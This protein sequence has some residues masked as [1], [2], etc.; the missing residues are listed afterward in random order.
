VSDA[1]PPDLDYRR[2][3]MASPNAYAVLSPDLRIIDANPAW[4]SLVHGPP[5][6]YIGR[7]FF[8]A[9]PAR[10]D[11]AARDLRAMFHRVLDRKRPETIPLIHY[12]LP[13]L[14]D[15]GAHGPWQDRYWT[16]NCAPLLGNDGTVVAILAGPIDITDLVTSRE[17]PDD[18]PGGA[19]LRL[20]EQLAGERRRFRQLMQQAPGFIAVGHGS[21]HVFELVNDAYYQLVGHRDIIGKPVRE[22]LPE[23]EGQGFY[24]LL[25]RVYATGEPFIGRAMPIQLQL[26]PGAPPVERYIDFIYQ[27]ILGEDGAVTGIFVQGHDV[28]DAHELAVRVSHQA[29]HDALTGLVNRREFEARLSRLFDG[30][31]DSTA[32][33]ALIYLDLDQFKVVNDT[34]GH[35]AGDELLRQVADVLRRHV[36][37]CHT[38]ARLGGDEFGLLLEDTGTESARALAETLRQAIDD[39]EYTRDQR[40]FGCSASLGVVAFGSEIGGITDALSAADSACFLAKEK[41]RNRVQMHW[42]DDDELAERRREM[43]W[44]GRLREALSDGRILLYAQRIAALRAAPERQHVELLVRLR[45][46]DGS[47][48]PPMAFIP[49]AERY[50]VM[51]AVDRHVIAAA[52]RHLASMAPDERSRIS[53]SVNLSGRTL[54][55]EN[56]VP[57]IRGLLDAMPVH[58]GEICFEVTETA[59]V[60][61]LAHTTRLLHELRAM[62]FCFALDDFGSG[63]SS[64]SYLKHLPVDFLKID[65]AFIRNVRHDRADAAMVEAIARVAKVMDIR[66]VAEYVED[67]ETCTLLTGLGVDYAQGFGVH[68]P[69]PLETLC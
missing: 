29:A 20:N 16:V 52:F 65:G 36:H 41:G 14:P 7:Y 25:D 9:L 28:T 54:S 22:A 35:A 31:R 48:V 6:H 49:A 40:T 34:C 66:T 30:L 67:A 46:V 61:N 39:L 42:A 5:D 10:M 56:L 60:H 57:F 69:E 3:L 1:T 53:L 51:P 62:G 8:D 17:G 33:H 2:L 68:V 24:E 26:R 59:A 37:P 4:L 64:F 44:V 21:D 23:L 43:D 18:V 32:Q 50:G 27:P 45:D 58:R 19:A 15:G 47:I 11:D 63:M 12:P 38:L 55:D 13:T